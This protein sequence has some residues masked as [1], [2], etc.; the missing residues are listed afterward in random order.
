MHSVKNLLVVILL[1]GVSY[2]AYQVITTPETGSESPDTEELVLEIPGLAPRQDPE[3]EPAP[4]AP[5]ILPPEIGSSSL[6]TPERPKSLAAEMTLPEVPMPNAPNPISPPQLKD[7]EAFADTLTP[8]MKDL[9]P[10]TGQVPKLPSAINSATTIGGGGNFRSEGQMTKVA[11]KPTPSPAL[12]TPSGEFLESPKAPAT[13]D[14]NG[15]QAMATQGNIKEALA[16]LSKNYN[17]PLTEADKLLM[18]KWLDSLAGRVIYSTDHCLYSQPYIVRTGD[19]L[20][21][22]GRQWNVPAQLI[23]NVN[24]NNIVDPQNLTPGTELKV[25]QGPFNAVI[26]VERQEMTLFLQGMYAGRFA[27]QL[28]QD[29]QGIEYGSFMVQEKLRGQTYNA[30]G[31]PIAAGDPQN[32]YGKYWIGLNGNASIHESNPAAGVQDNRG[33]IRLASKDAADVFGI[34]STGSQVTID[35]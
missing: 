23:Y 19:T 32:P 17:A 30:G 27:I 7:P 29:G 34:L 16:E 22:I 31:Q 18:L 3:S 11:P 26:N 28:G 9:N 8:P 5:P 4:L 2:G 6:E 33:S 14:W 25:I 13:I 21:A 35:R 10:P 1:M 15:I 24:A 20:E 12:P